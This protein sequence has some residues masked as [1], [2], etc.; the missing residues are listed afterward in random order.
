MRRR[1]RGVRVIRLGARREIAVLVCIGSVVMLLVG[2]GAAFATRQVAEN[3]ALEESVRMTE[4]LST[5]I[6]K[7]ILPG[8]LNEDPAKAEELA[9]IIKDR[10]SDG[11]LTEVT[12]W[13]ADGRVLFSN[14]PDDIGDV[15]NPVPES[16]VD[17]L[18]GKTSAA[19]EDDPPEADG[20]SNTDSRSLSGST[21]P[22]RYV[23]VYVPLKVAGLQPLVFEAYY[24]YGRVDRLAD[25]LV[26][27]ILPL[28]LVPLLI[29]Q[30]VQILVAVSLA[31]RLKRHENDRS[32]LLERALSSSDA[33]RVRFAADL[34][35]GPIQ[36]LAG[37]G[38][39]LGAVAPSVD[40]RHAP[41]VA[42]VQ[43]ALQR[44]VQSLR[45]LMTDLYPPDLDDGNLNEAIGVLTAPARTAGIEVDL[46]LDDVAGLGKDQVTTLYRV[47]R[48][49]LANVVKHSR[50]S[51][52][53]V[54]LSTRPAVPAEFEQRWVRLVIA[55]D[56]VGAEVSQLDRRA[57]G[58]L[59]LRLLADRVESLDGRFVIATGPGQGTSIEVELPIDLEDR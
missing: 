59:G 40:P 8:Y 32:R 16:V 34:H 29:V 25:R 2:L 21:G 17:A 22:A 39:A 50:A 53:T 37:I 7:P 55:D 42:R 45:T 12:V 36:D 33:E 38:Y 13:A 19:F 11:Y 18:A 44:S 26:S 54:S 27:Q 51:H 23:E 6:V 56:G 43:E 58:H 24:D 48:E 15:I 49:S 41:L 28:V 57:E 5:L 30:A 31:R 20:Q 4:R 1:A 9:R 10:M 3:Q 14:E 46:Q 52:L 47:A 35:D